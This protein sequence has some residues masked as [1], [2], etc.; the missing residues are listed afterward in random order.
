[1]V[2]RHPLEVDILV[3]I[4]VPQQVNFTSIYAIY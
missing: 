4:Q 1:M 3:R 2:G